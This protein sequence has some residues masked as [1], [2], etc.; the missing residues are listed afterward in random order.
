MRHIF[1]HVVESGH[2]VSHEDVSS[3][4][5]YYLIS[6]PPSKVCPLCETI[7]PLRLSSTGLLSLSVYFPLRVR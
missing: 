2:F 3:S 7:V 1:E 4:V 6:L 5:S